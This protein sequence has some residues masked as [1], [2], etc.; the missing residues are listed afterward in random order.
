MPGPATDI[1][2][3]EFLDLDSFFDGDGCYTFEIK[4]TNQI[5]TGIGVDDDGDGSK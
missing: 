1:N 5:Y 4:V 2:G 3:I